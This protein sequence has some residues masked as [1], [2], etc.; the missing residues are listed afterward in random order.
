MY[1]ILKIVFSVLICIP[2]LVAVFVLFGKLSDCIINIDKRR[3]SKRQAM[4]DEQERRR[5]FDLEYRQRHGDIR[6]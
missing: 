1:D 3:R 5:K 6:R 4:L 2:M